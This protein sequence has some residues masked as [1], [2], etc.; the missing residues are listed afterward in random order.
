MDANEF[1]SN[2]KK[3]KVAKYNMGVD[4]EAPAA[5]P[6]LK[7]NLENAPKL[8]EPSFGEKAKKAV[9]GSDARD[10]A[11]H[12]LLTVVIPATKSFIWDMITSG[13]ERAIYGEN[14]RGPRTGVRGMVSKASAVYHSAGNGPRTDPP[15]DG[16]RSSQVPIAA[17]TRHDFQD[18]V[19]GSH[20]EAQETLNSL[21]T[22]IQEYGIVTVATFY[23]AVGF[24]SDDYQANKWGWVELNDARPVPHQGG[25]ILDMPKPQHLDNI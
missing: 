18:V 8:R 5:L 6:A 9:F 22:Y 4:P 3:S 13:A 10:V 12:L 17:R 14:G 19:F 25:Y 24:T 7:L 21:R 23:A 2:S 11:N 16:R 1:P 20:I 15:F